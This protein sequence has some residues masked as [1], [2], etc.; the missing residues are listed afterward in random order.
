MK[1]GQRIKA[2][3]LAI[4]ERGRE[5]PVP[6][7]IF[8]AFDQDKADIQ[9]ALALIDLRLEALERSGRPHD[10]HPRQH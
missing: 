3:W 5:P 9:A 1:I 10:N 7:P 4:W 6:D 8:Q 2:A